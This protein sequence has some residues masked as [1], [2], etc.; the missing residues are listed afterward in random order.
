M[1][2]VM[3]DFDTE[4][5]YL[6]KMAIGTVIIALVLFTVSLICYYTTLNDYCIFFGVLSG[7]TFEFLLLVVAERLELNNHKK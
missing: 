6:R 4:K 3:K 1:T 5:K 2:Y 7:L